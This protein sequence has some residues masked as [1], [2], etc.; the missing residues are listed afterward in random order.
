MEKRTIRMIINSDLEDVALI[1]TSVNKLCSL[2][3]LSE[4]DC[5]NVE[6]SVVEV[7]TN[8]IRHAYNNEKGHEVEVEFSIFPENRIEVSVF[9][10]GEEIKGKIEPKLDFD[11]NDLSSLPEG[12]M[13]LY[14]I[15]NIMDDVIV[16]KINGRNRWKLVKYLDKKEE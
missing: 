12:G 4:L 9:D 11:P 14:L 7:C 6:L 1:G 15:F 13:G 8:S 16:D 10:S 3:G 2:T 5:Y